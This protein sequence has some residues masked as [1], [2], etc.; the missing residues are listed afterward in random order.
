MPNWATM[1]ETIADH[2]PT[3]PKAAVAISCHEPQPWPSSTIVVPRCRPGLDGRALLPGVL[4]SRI[5]SMHGLR[6]GSFAAASLMTVASDSRRDD[7]V[8]G[9]AS[10]LF[11]RLI[12]MPVGGLLL[13]PVCLVERVLRTLPVLRSSSSAERRSCAVHA[14][15]CTVSR[16]ACCERKAS[17]SSPQP[18]RTR[19][20]CAVAHGSVST[21]L[22]IIVLSMFASAS[23]H[24][25]PPTAAIARGAP[26]AEPATP[27][28][29]TASHTQLARARA[30]LPRAR[31]GS[32][33]SCSRKMFMNHMNAHL[34]VLVYVCLQPRP[35]R[36]PV[37]EPHGS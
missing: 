20:A 4:L 13:S 8:S 22:P 33:V 7:V 10:S 36:G 25:E 9:S 5:S 6:D 18:E 37:H 30:A 21:P 19:P 16:M 31:L 29:S 27:L 2:R 1:S 17:S 32:S 12:P 26:C 28:V 23:T 11:W 3:L 15:H 24:G 14:A 34:F 35:A